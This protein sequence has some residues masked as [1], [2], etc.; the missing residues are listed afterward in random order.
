MSIVRNILAFLGFLPRLDQGSSYLLGAIINHFLTIM[1]GIG[2]LNTLFYVV[3]S[4]IF[5]HSLCFILMLLLWK[6][7]SHPVSR[8]V[9][10][11]S[12]EK[13]SFV[14]HLEM[15]TRV[16]LLLKQIQ[17]IKFQSHT[18]LITFIAFLSYMAMMWGTRFLTSV[19]LLCS[20]SSDNHGADHPKIDLFDITFGCE[21]LRRQNTAFAGR[22]NLARGEGAIFR[23]TCL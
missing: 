3:T 10:K 13:H 4:T 9:G 5:W 21:Q 16:Y 19:Q 18:I 23:S 1:T 8:K 20:N 17:L 6:H 14:R 7:K 2:A 11:K 15:R 22:I 12:D